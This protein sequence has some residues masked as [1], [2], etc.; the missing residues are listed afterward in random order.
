MPASLSLIETASFR[1]RDRA[2]Q[3]SQIQDHIRQTSLP[4]ANIRFGRPR[5]V[6]EFGVAN[7]VSLRTLRKHLTPPMAIDVGGSAPDYA[8]QMHCHMQINLRSGPSNS[9]ATASVRRASKGTTMKAAV[10]DHNGPPE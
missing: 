3:I 8:T 1:R 5:F 7:T 6:P 9:Y 10:Y 4:H 2:A